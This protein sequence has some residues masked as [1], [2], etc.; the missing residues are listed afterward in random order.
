MASAYGTLATGGAHVDP[1]PVISVTDAQG[2][3][4]WQARPDPKQVLEPAGGHGRERHPAGRR[5][6]RHR[7]LG[8]HRA[9]RRSARPA[10]PRPTPTRGS[11]AR[12]L[13][14]P[15]RS[16]SASMRVRSRW[17]RPAPASPCSAARWPAQIW[18]L[19]M[20]KRGGRS[21][22]ARLPDPDVGYVSV[23]VDVTQSTPLPAE[24]LH[25]AAEHR[26]AAVHR[27]HRADRD[28]H[29]AHAGAVGGRA[30]G[31]RP[32]PGVG[33]RSRSRKPAST[34]RFESR[35]LDP[36]AWHR[37]L[38]AS[39]G[40]HRG[41]ADEH[42]HDHGR[43]RTPRSPVREPRRRT[44]PA[45]ADER[46]AGHE[47]APGAVEP[48]PD[49]DPSGAY[50]RGRSAPRLPASIQISAPRTRSAP[51]WHGRP[52]SA[53]AS[54]PGPEQRSSTRS[55]PRRSPSAAEPFE[56][57]ERRAGGRRSPRRAAARDDVQHPVVAVREVHVQAPG[58]PEHHGVAGRHATE[59]VARRVPGLVGLG[60]D[61]APGEPR[62]VGHDRRTSVR[63]SRSGATSIAARSKNDLGRR[64]RLRS[65]P[66]GGT[67]ASFV[68][69]QA[70]ITSSFVSHP[71]CAV[72]TPNRIMS[73]WPT[74][75]ES[76]SIANC[77]P[78]RRAHSTCSSRRSSRSG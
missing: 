63:P 64:R 35:S 71:R 61:D 78:C 76:V 56:R 27:G 14:S 9:T 43:P 32:R 16:G 7:T 69:G 68:I 34:S 11:W 2:E 51:S 21:A 74:A 4:L 58:R 52:Q 60:L 77:T 59:A 49:A 50:P 6:L 57:L 42:R 23:S 47:E 75:C 24:R 62:A 41:D 54:L 36:A 10:R 26:H 45:P 38:P 72:A 53:W 18:R 70:L 19:F 17:N 22:G 29:H 31:D 33:R 37:D 66:C 46:V 67:A 20:V 13:S 44:R 15:R 8:D 40:R 25:A 39:V 73:R 3:T 55:R 30:V 65:R 1:V 28:V 48:D 12:S 5:E